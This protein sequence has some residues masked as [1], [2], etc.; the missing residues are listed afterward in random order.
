MKSWKTNCGAIMFAIGGVLTAF[1]GKCPIT[2]AQFWME[3]VGQ[4]LMAT[5]GA[6][7]AIGIGAKIDRGTKALRRL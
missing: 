6:L 7:G 5:G 3:L 2:E 1:S 4:I